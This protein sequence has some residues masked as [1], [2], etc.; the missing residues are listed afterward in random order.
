MENVE[1]VSGG[2]HGADALGS[3]FANERGLRLTQHQDEIE[4]FGKAAGYQFCNRL[5]ALYATHAIVFS[6]NRS[7]VVQNLIETAS[8]ECVR[9][10]VI[11]V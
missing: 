7:D 4:R 6:D 9:V 3:R 11:P 8:Q 2:C 1:I 10:A 5:W